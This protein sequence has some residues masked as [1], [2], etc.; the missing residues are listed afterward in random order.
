MEEK[1][2]KKNDVEEFKKYLFQLQR[3]KLL[4]GLET[5]TMNGPNMME[6]IQHINMMI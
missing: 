6:M 3:K 5:E 1:E 4:K 2:P